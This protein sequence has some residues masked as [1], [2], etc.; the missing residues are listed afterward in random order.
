MPDRLAI[1]GGK[2]VRETLLPYG[3]QSVD[4]NDIAAVVRTL[5]S[6]WLTTGPTVADFER[7]F[8]ETVGAR[9]AVAVSSGTAALHAAMFAIGIGPDDEVV[10]PA[11]TFAASAS[12]VL[13]QGGTPVFADVDPATLLIDSASVEAL[14][15]ERTRAI[16]AVDYAGQPCEYEALRTIT[17]RHGLHLIADA[18]H[19]LGGT[20][21]GR[22]VGSLADLSVFS[23]HPVKA[24]TAGEGGVVATDDPAAAERMQVFRNHG[25]TAD[26]R[27][28]SEAGSW[29]YEIHELGFNYRLT[30]L[31]CALA[32]S[33]LD[34]LGDWVERRRAIAARYDR[35]LD[36]LCG[37]TPL[38]RR[39]EASHA[40]HLYVV[41][42]DPSTITVGRGEV[43]EAL[44]AEGIGVNVHY[45][46]VHLHP[47]YRRRL[48]TG[49][50]M[51]PVAEKA[52]DEI[53]SLPLYP[54]M[55]D[56]DVEDVIEA[57][58]KVC[59]AYAT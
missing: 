25:I 15:G 29:V 18:C 45:I 5:R 9:H 33:Q 8:A 17:K 21:S 42:L 30:D 7:I 26:H 11:M 40:Y 22:P 48:G 13:Y 43:F 2:P 4:D 56:T 49:P 37:M 32:M 53:L 46:P 55:A 23:F 44:R 28:R 34:R 1:H 41:R 57:V 36:Q 47:L 35:A 51:C 50:G 3:R 58:T 59:Q 24:I 12:C 52:Y 6:N 20:D 16:V 10:V 38:M 39:P 19:A 31:Q 54:A 27:Q 14:I